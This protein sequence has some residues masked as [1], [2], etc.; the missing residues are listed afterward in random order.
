M[1]DVDGNGVIDIQEMTKIVQVSYVNLFI[2]NHDWKDKEYI[3]LVIT[4]KELIM[5]KYLFLSYVLK[6]DE[7]MLLLGDRN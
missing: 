3:T 7:D 6:K 4:G 5:S 2:L 1:Y